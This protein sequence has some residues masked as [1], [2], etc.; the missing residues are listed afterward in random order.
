MMRSLLMKSLKSQRM[1]ASFMVIFHFFFNFNSLGMYLEGARWNSTTHLLDDSKPKQ[2]YTELP[3]CWFVP[4]KNRKKPEAV[5]Y[6][7]KS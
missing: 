6:F 3:M 1:D 2:L 5:N 4:K 7:R